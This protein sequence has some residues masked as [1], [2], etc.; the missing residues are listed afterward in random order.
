NIFLVFFIVIGIMTRLSIKESIYFRVNIKMQ[1][2]LIKSSASTVRLKMFGQYL[3]ERNIRILYHAGFKKIY[4]KFTASDKELFENKIKRKLSSLKNLSISFTDK[5]PKEAF[6]EL[7]TNQFMYLNAFSEKSNFIKISQNTFLKPDSFYEIN[8]RKTLI[9]SE[10][11]I[12]RHIRRQSG[13]IVAQTINKRISIPLSRLL[14]HAG[15]HPNVI[16]LTNYTLGLF[17]VY[18]LLDSSHTANIAAGLIIQAV[19]IIDGCDGE[20][21]RMKI[22]FSKL[23]GILDTVCD[24]TLAILIIA[25]ATRR[26]YMAFDIELFI[27]IFSMITLGVIAIIGWNTV[28]LVKYSSSYSFSAFS[29][30]FLSPLSKTSFL[31][32]LISILQYFV[33]KE[34]YSLSIMFFCFFNGIVY[35]TFLFAIFGSVGFFLVNILCLK[36]FPSLRKRV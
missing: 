33:R 11:Y 9:T 26:V 5:N 7:T 36:Y 14:A 3:I 28:Y 29:K 16:T 27:I 23:G 22:R 21:A 20:V 8:D 10:K 32:K 4:L 2:A 17:G 25:A 18:L 12:S 31:A 13:G 6:L 30:E 1:T 15:I 24:H 34:V 35:Y 19:S